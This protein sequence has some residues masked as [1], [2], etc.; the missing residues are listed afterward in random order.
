M[1]EKTLSIAQL[2]AHEKRKDEG[3]FMKIV[4][5]ADGSFKVTKVSL[6]GYKNTWN[7][8]AA[9]DKN[10]G[11]SKYMPDMIYDPSFRIAGERQVLKT[12]LKIW[13]SQ[14]KSIFTRDDIE[15]ILNNAFSRNN[16]ES[17]DE[18]IIFDP[19]FDQNKSFSLGRGTKGTFASNF[20]REIAEASAAVKDKAKTKEAE[21]KSKNYLPL[22]HEKLSAALEY[23]KDHQGSKEVSSPRTSRGG[24]RR[25]PVQRTSEYFKTLLEAVPSGKYLD[26]SHTTETG[27]KTSTKELPGDKSIVQYYKLGSSSD[28][29]LNKA[30][31]TISAR[32]K[33]PKE[34][35][36]NFLM[37]AQGWDEDK[38]SNYYDSIVKP[39][40][41]APR[42]AATKKGSAKEAASPTRRRRNDSDEQ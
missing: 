36:V 24:G 23:L 34:G 9:N 16:F 20:R 8:N 3:K 26:V 13:K 25:G 2:F 15:T 1:A 35:V 5:G 11:L 14:E 28:R 6:S 40:G 10:T 38:A 27:T 37:I 12:F 22:E 39:I 42:L 19:K 41:S 17:Q 21:E 4:Q 29:T 30:G 33:D 18:Q 31:F 7:E 32:S